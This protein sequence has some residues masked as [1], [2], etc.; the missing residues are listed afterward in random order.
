LL[1]ILSKRERALLKRSCELSVLCTLVFGVALVL[2]EV[3]GRMALGR[4]AFFPVD[5][6]F[7]IGEEDTLSFLGTTV[8]FLGT[9]VSFLGTGVSPPPENLEAISATLGRDGRT[10]EPCI[11]FLHRG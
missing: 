2:V 6:F 10:T 1:P 3:R 7:V 8:S 5:S 9:T 11:L 4:S